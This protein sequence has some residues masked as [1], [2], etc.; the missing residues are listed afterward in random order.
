MDAIKG[1]DD[2][3]NDDDNTDGDSHDEVDDDITKLTDVAL[4]C[5]EISDIRNEWR[6]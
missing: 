6:L 5:C 1:N 4:N 2:Y 3:N